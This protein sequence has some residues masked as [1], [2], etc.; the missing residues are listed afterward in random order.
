[1][2]K[3]EFWDSSKMKTIKLNEFKNLNVFLSIALVLLTNLILPMIYSF[4]TNFILL[5][6]SILSWLSIMR[7]K[8]FWF[9]VNEIYF[10]PFHSRYQSIWTEECSYSKFVYWKCGRNLNV[11]VRYIYSDK[12]KDARE[13]FF[14]FSVI[15]KN[16]EKKSNVFT[17]FI[18]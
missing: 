18:A 2:Q 10:Y 4:S 16:N 7:E 13:S 14:F 5:L 8:N 1:M 15:V 9:R 6:N 3:R 12:R 11:A 17:V